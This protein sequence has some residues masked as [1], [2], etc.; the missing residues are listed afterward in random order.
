VFARLKRAELEVTEANASDFL[1]R[2]A[3]LEKSIAQRVASRFRERHLV[4][5]RFLAADPRDPYAGRA[6]ELL[7]LLEGEKRFQ[8]HKVGLPKAM[9]LEHAIGKLSV[10]RQKN[11]SRRMVFKPPDW[12]HTRRNA[13]KKIL[14]RATTFRI[15]HG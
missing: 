8:F 10:I 13:V 15:A 6:H 1:N 5:R 11:Q 2:M 9:R 4:P 7:D 14:Q 12:K 3:R